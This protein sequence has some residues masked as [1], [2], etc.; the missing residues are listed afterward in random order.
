MVGRKGSGA[1][2]GWLMRVGRVE[3]QD[4]SGSCQIVRKKT[5]KNPAEK[6]KGSRCASWRFVKRVGGEGL[7]VKEQRLFSSDSEGKLASR[8]QSKQ[9]SGVENWGW[10]RECKPV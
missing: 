1:G 7:V 10:A 6:Q 8:R 2:D 9:M 5:I 4:D 3:V